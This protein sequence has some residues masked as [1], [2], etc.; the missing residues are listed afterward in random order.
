MD[1]VCNIEHAKN[2]R[3]LTKALKTGNQ[4]CYEGVKYYLEKNINVECSHDKAYGSALA[5]TGELEDEG[6][7]IYKMTFRIDTNMKADDC[8]DWSRPDSI[9]KLDLD[10]QTRNW[11][12]DCSGKFE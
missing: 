10:C 3:R 7:I 2:I 12:L 1:V 11:I 8:S 4:L 6:L 5:I 9:E